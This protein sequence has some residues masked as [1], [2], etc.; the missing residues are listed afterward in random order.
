M[1]MRNEA[2]PAN[3]PRWFDPRHRQIGTWAFILNRVTAIG[4]TVYLFLHLA[5]LSKLTQG[6]AGYQSFLLLAKT[7]LVK[8]GELLV[9]AA[10]LIHGLNGLRIALTSFGVGV[11]R[12]KMIFIVLLILAVTGS[13][14]FGYR[15]FFGD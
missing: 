13:A 9:I 12:Q 6:E 4:L 2:H 5:V 3:W 10:G 14:Y 8:F 1:A 7:P 15:M 11:Q